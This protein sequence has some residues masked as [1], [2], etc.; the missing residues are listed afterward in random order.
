MRKPLKPPCILF[1]DESWFYDDLSGRIMYLKHATDTNPYTNV[2]MYKLNRRFFGVQYNTSFFK[3]MWTLPHMGFYKKH[4]ITLYTYKTHPCRVNLFDVKKGIFSGCVVVPT[5]D[6]CTTLKSNSHICIGFQGKAFTLCPHRGIMKGTIYDLVEYNETAGFNL[7]LKNGTDVVF[8]RHYMR[9]HSNDPFNSVIAQDIYFSLNSLHRRYI[10]SFR[11]EN[12]YYP[13]T[14]EVKQSNVMVKTLC[15]Y[16]KFNPRFSFFLHVG[17]PGPRGI[18]LTEIYSPKDGLIGKGLGR[19]TFTETI[20]SFHP[21]INDVVRTHIQLNPD[22][23]SLLHMIR[24]RNKTASMK[25]YL[26]SVEIYKRVI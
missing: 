15:C 5:D 21:V 10:L 16:L 2:L 22:D 4:F 3:E 18:E 1:K 19:M 8:G 6:I 26:A 13:V 24:S 23:G 9:Y 17:L 11:K 7:V 20:T 25:E 12:N 14:Y